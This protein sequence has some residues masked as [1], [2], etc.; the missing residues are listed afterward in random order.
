MTKRRLYEMCCTKRK[1]KGR[2]PGP[3]IRQFLVIKHQE[4]NITGTEEEED[5]RDQL[6]PPATNTLTLGG[7]GGVRNKTGPDKER[8]TKEVILV[9]LPIIM[10]VL[11]D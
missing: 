7:R 11:T 8:N 3:S 4:D 10:H 2:A 6:I 5:Y 1:S 9:Y